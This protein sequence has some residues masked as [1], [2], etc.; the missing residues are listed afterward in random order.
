M[1]Q[2][3]QHGRLKAGGFSL[4]EIVVALSILA[5]ISGAIFSILWQ[6]ADTAT[7]VRDRDRRDEEMAHFIDLLRASIELLPPDGTLSVV[8]PE[9][10][11][12]GF[13]ELKIGNSAT[14]FTF[15]EI[16]GTVDE[17]VISLRPSEKLTE[18]GSPTYDLA[19]SRPDF[20]PDEEKQG[21]MAFRASAEDFL[22]V[23]ED[24]RPWMTLL[25][26][27][28]SAIWEYWDD[29]QETWEPDRLDPSKLPELIALSLGDSERASPLRIVFEVPEQV[30]NPVESAPAGTESTTPATTNDDRTNR[31]GERDGAQKGQGPRGSG[32]PGQREEGGDRG[33]RQPGGGGSTGPGDGGGRPGGRP[34][35]A[36]GG[37]PGGGPGGGGASPSG[38]GSTS[39]G[40]TT[41]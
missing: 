32:Q 1:K 6:A 13:A 9:E 20:V 37:R 35:G 18:D 10:T 11:T 24:G 26:G 38:G 34:G 12:T 40:G 27:L 4:F 16:V 41:R 39:G 2:I 25:T 15:G 14:A 31:G 29:E 8:P 7:E 36:P 5:M 22:P 3:A 21:G 33:G 23:D 30:V 19:I 17:A 28:T